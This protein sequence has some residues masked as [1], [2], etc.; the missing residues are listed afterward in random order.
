MT[1]PGLVEL[2]GDANVL[3]NTDY[4]H[5]DGTFPWGIDRLLAQPIPEASKRRIL[6]DNAERAFGF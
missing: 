3:F 1:L 4:P 5:P 2:A 6:W